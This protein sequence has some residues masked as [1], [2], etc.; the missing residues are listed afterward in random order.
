MLK[1]PFGLNGDVLTAPQGKAFNVFNQHS[2]KDQWKKRFQQ[3][4]NNKANPFLRT[5]NDDVDKY[6]VSLYLEQHGLTHNRITSSDNYK[7]IVQTQLMI[8]QYH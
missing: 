4:S 2:E 7:E 1:M 5:T 3:L 8:N 6:D